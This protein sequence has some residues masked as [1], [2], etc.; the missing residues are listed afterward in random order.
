MQQVKKTA[1]QVY[2]KAC[3]GEERGEE[4]RRG[5]DKGEGSAAGLKEGKREGRRG[6]RQRVE[7]TADSYSRSSL[8]FFSLLCASLSS[9]HALSEGMSADS[10]AR[11]RTDLERR[12][13]ALPLQLSSHPLFLPFLLFLCCLSSFL[14]SFF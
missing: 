10:F 7:E 4:R 9:H 13:I 1:E 8:L 2:E 12:R 14:F 5:D 6:G 11:L 3:D